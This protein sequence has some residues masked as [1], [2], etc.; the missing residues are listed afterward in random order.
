MKSHAETSHPDESLLKEAAVAIGGA[1]G[2]V[3]ALAKSTFT[4]ATTAPAASAAPTA[5]ARKKIPK[6]P[7]KNKSRLPR[8]EKK[9]LA[10]RKVA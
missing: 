5:P 6:L 2:T 8:K 7:A 4:P 3:A 9:A 1:A 10:K